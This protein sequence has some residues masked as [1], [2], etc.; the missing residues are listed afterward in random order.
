MIAWVD[1]CGARDMGIWLLI[2]RSS[3]GARS[4]GDME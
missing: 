1:P 4:L 2:A 3:G